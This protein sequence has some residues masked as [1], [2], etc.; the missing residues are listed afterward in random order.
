[1]ILVRLVIAVE[2]E[3]ASVVWVTIASKSTYSLF[4][5]HLSIR[6]GIKLP[7]CFSSSTRSL[8]EEEL[9]EEE[10]ELDEDLDLFLFFLGDLDLPLPGAFV[11]QLGQYLLVRTSTTAQPE[12]VGAL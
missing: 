3:R 1:M 11:P 7:E 10:D 6:L 5:I 12:Q 9:E 2:P 4:L 8:E